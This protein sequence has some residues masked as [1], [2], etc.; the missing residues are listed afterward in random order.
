[1]CCGRRFRR[2]RRPPVQRH[3]ART[4]DTRQPERGVGNGSGAALM[5]VP[6]TQA[7]AG[8]RSD[9][10][11]TAAD[12]TLRYRVRLLRLSEKDSGEGKTV[13]LVNSKVLAA[14][15]TLML[16]TGAGMASAMTPALA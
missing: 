2:R 9:C 3:R 1:D 14:A 4:G 8:T 6:Q 11:R 13:M 5:G 15:A 10:R 12:Q 16:V 7:C